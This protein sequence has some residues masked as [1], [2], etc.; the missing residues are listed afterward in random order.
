[1]SAPRD[2]ATINLRDWAEAQEPTWRAVYERIFD[3]LGIGR[4]TTVLDAGCGSGYAL[5]VARERGATVCGLDVS[6]GLIEIARERLPGARIEIGDLEHLPFEDA[7]FD[8]VTGFNAFQFADDVVAALREAR[9][10]CR[11]DGTITMMVW[12]PRDVCD[13]LSVIIPAVTPISP[14]PS[15]SDEPA[16]EQAGVIEAFM[17]AAGL[18]PVASETFDAVFTYPDASVAMRALAA[19]PPCRRAAASAGETAMRSA[20]ERVLAEFTR[21]DG[22]VAHRN[23]LRVVFATKP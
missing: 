9:R 21:A 2:F 17:E 6:P 23:R 5:L 12:G 19:A 11:K 10:V 16:F 20:L 18:A 8:A 13:L 3:R 7:S 4:E 1:M 15:S 14:P 22:S